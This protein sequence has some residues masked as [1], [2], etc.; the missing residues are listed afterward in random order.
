[1]IGG[2]YNA[3]GLEGPTIYLLGGL[4]RRLHRG[5]AR[6]LVRGFGARL[7]TGFR[8]RLPLLR[9]EEKAHHEGVRNPRPA[10]AIAIAI[11]M[12][13]IMGVGAVPVGWVPSTVASTAG[14]TARWSAAARA[15]PTAPPS[16]A[17]SAIVTEGQ[18]Q[19][20]TVSLHGIVLWPA[21]R[22]STDGWFDGWV[23]GSP[24]G[25]ILGKLVG[26]DVGIEVGRPDGC[27]HTSQH[28]E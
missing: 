14:P 20:T 7:A 27:H 11:A 28:H 3:Q 8:R 2:T 17:A 16:V 6:G 25:C 24:E 10:I 18:T 1:M 23:E 4:D 13:R 12:P 21:L 26:Y 9:T 15:V 19:M 5:L 22:T